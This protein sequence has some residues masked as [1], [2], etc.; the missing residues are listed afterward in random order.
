MKKIISITLLTLIVSVVAGVV[1]APH[2]FAQDSEESTGIPKQTELKDTSQ[3]KLNAEL[4]QNFER[5]KLDDKKK[6]ACANHEQTIN[7]RIGIVTDRSKNQFARI[8][9]IYKSITDFYT[10]KGLK[11]ENYDILIENVE[12]AKTA[13]QT[14]L[15]TIKT[16][17]TFSCNSDGPKADIQSFLNARLNKSDAFNDYRDAVKALIKAVRQASTPTDNTT[18]EGKQS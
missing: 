15:Q 17:P 9:D 10:K 12:V 3:H 16:T 5:Q 18:K 14:A 13:A 6:A 11:I 7:G 8:S 1:T 4:R 2:I